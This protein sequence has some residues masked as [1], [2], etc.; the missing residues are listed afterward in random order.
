[1]SKVVLKLIE[2]V[3]NVDNRVR[4]NAYESGI[5]MYVPTES[6]GTEN[7]IANT[8]IITRRVVKSDSF[9]PTFDS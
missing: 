7:S 9:F 5:A 6:N 4:P 8:K 1:M 2:S 3:A